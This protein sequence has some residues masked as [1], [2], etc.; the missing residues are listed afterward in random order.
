MTLR[1]LDEA[2]RYDTD[3]F[4]RCP[5]NRHDYCD[6]YEWHFSRYRYEK[7][8][9]WEIGVDRGG[10]LKVWVDYF[11]NATVI[12]IDIKP[13]PET[14]PLPERSIWYHGDAT[15]PGVISS[16]ALEYP[17]GIVLDDGSHMASQMRKSFELIFPLT[18]WLYAVEDIGTQYEFKHGKGFLDAQPFTDFAKEQCDLLATLTTPLV[19]LKRVCWEPGQ[20]YFYK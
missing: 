14:F 7:F 20:V 5:I 2:N 13:K 3:K 1:E 8:N 4:G 19:P 15:N 6:A 9:F 17:P 18:K 11:P 16:L 12:G 10:S